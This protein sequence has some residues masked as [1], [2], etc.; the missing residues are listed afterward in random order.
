MKSYT[1][2]TQQTAIQ[3]EGLDKFFGKKQVLHDLRF[4]VPEGS[5]T[6]FLGA[7]GSGKTTTLRML[8]GLIPVKKPLR[9]ENLK[10]LK[11]LS[12]LIEMIL[13]KHGIIS[14]LDE[15]IPSR[16]TKALEDIGAVVENPSFIE[17]MTGFDN[18][19]W[20][21]ALYKPVDDDRILQ[22][23]EMV[24][25][26]DATFQKF[27]TY[28]TGMKQR[29]G[30]AFGILHKPRLLMLDEPTSGMDPAGRVQMREILKKIHKEDKTSIF[31]SSHLLDEVQR[32][33]DYVVIINKGHT[34]AQGYVK[35]LL[36]D[37][38]EQW[39]IRVSKSCRDKTEKMLKSMTETKVSFE[40]INDGF[41]VKMSQGD[42]AKINRQ[43]VDSGIDVI[44]L[45]PKERTLEEAFI[46]LTTE[47][48]TKEQNNA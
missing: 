11:N 3:V 36:S 41:L 23:I 20:F 14:L 24:G 44:A 38:L 22:S 15:P 10:K 40:K 7:N 34:V 47:Q 1:K 18:L 30:V 25:L 39:E 2:Q 29:L 37:P 5:I 13:P 16:R 43:L 8:L 32:L 27:G 28:S 46:D 48:E 19:K 26:K 45:I 35:D 21:G 33:C 31:L 9:I 6:G 17:T 12:E 4:S 42:S